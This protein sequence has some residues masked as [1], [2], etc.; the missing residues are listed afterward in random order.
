MAL[1]TLDSQN[2]PLSCA[3]ELGPLFP[4]LPA[5]DLEFKK[6]NFS[7]Q[8]WGRE[9]DGGRESQTQVCHI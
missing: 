9:E 1:A 4:S 6:W 7:V 3:A 5:P 8:V 2:T